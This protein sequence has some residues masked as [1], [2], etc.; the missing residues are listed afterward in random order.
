MSNEL[1]NLITDLREQIQ[2][3]NEL[4]VETMETA[5]PVLETAQPEIVPVRLAKMKIAGP[6]VAPLMTTNPIPPLNTMPVGEPGTSTTMGN[7]VPI[8]S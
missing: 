3:L 2:Y 5:L 8:P 6:E 4:G 1:R 7:G